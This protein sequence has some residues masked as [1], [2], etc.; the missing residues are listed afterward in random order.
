MHVSL[1]LVLRFIVFDKHL[2]LHNTYCFFILY[3]NAIKTVISYGISIRLRTIHL[4]H[5]H[6]ILAYNFLF[7]SYLLQSAFAYFFC[8][9]TTIAQYETNTFHAFAKL[10][11]TFHFAHKCVGTLTRI[12]RQPLTQRPQW[13]NYWGGKDMGIYPPP[14]ALLL[15][16]NYLYRLLLI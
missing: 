16:I 13:R 5:S 2:I 11:L 3:T 1:P 6:S 15:Y 4:H 7:R 10:V 8:T 14:R 9:I 12:A